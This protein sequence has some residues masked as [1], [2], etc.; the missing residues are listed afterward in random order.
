MN[1]KTLLLKIKRRIWNRFVIKSYN[2]TFYPLFYSSFWNLLFYKNKSQNIISQYFSTYPN[3]GAGIGHQMANWISGYWWAIKFELNYAYIP[4]PNQSWNSFLG[5]GENEVQVNNLLN[6]GYRKVL[7]PMFHED[8]KNG[9]ERNKKII[10]SYKN[11]KIIFVAE[12]DQGF[13]NHY[14]I[15]DVLKIKFFNAAARKNDV[16][17][18]SESSYN[19]AIHVRR[20]DIVVKNSNKNSNLTM[21]WQNN[22]YFVSILQ[23]VIEIIKTNKPI[24]IYLFSQGNRVDF[25]EFEK[26]KNIIFCLDMPPQES[27]LNMVYADLLITSKSSFSYK[28]ALISNGIKICPNDFWLG[29]PEQE[30]WIL[31]DEN[32]S[33]NREQLKRL[34]K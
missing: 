7:L 28:P 34:Y 13:S 24:R 2:K 4:F 30:D 31:A 32:G 15:M 19:I 8:D 20:G 1:F 12:Q 11:K 18:Y 23:A 22:S 25:N 29:Y 27:F 14:E 6:Q 21:R 10:N 16:K 26:F 5:F 33:F 17:T 3:P 9:F